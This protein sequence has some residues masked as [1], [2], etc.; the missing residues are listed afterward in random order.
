MI[1]YQLVKKAIAQS[2]LSSSSSSFR[3]TLPRMAPDIASSGVMAKITRVNF[4]PYTK[5]STKPVRNMVIAWMNDEILWPMPSLTLFRSLVMEWNEWEKWLMG[6]DQRPGETVT[7]GKRVKHLKWK[8]IIRPSLTTSLMHQSLWK[9]GRM[10]FT[11]DWWVMTSALEKR[12]HSF[13]GF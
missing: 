8:M 7:R 2:L 10:Y 4:H 12:F 13:P 5:P 3:P 6:Y 1:R 11:N 9:V